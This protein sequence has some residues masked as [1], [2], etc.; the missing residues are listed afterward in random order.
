MNSANVAKVYSRYGHD[1]IAVNPS[2]GFSFP[3][4]LVFY[5]TTNFASVMPRD[6]T[7]WQKY[8]ILSGT[9]H[10]EQEVCKK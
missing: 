5:K 4:T 3:E 1:D 10:P 2:L 8:I 7:F 6:T 9:S